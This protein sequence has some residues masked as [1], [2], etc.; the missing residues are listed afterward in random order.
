MVRGLH[1]LFNAAALFKNLQ[2]GWLTPS[3]LERYPIHWACH[4]QHRCKIVKGHHC[5]G[6]LGRPYL[7]YPS[8]QWMHKQLLWCKPSDIVVY[9]LLIHDIGM[10]HDRIQHE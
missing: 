10:F 9:N 8:I 3:Q 1:I 5:S 4:W 7:R 2:G 6:W